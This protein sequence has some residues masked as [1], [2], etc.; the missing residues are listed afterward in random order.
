MR[1]V[2][3]GAGELGTLVVLR[4]SPSTLTPY[5]PVADANIYRPLGQVT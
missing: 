3:T 1:I 5:T 4:P 2:W